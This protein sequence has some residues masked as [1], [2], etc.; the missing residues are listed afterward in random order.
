M[1]VEDI[2]EITAVMNT[3]RYLYPNANKIC[4]KCNKYILIDGYVC[5]GCGYDK[6]LEDNTEML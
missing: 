6:S 4:P 5:F 3:F 1:I 2:E